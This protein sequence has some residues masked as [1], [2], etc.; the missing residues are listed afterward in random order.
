MNDWLNELG[1]LVKGALEDGDIAEIV[2]SSA[3]AETEQSG[4]YHLQWNDGLS[5][6]PIYNVEL[7]EQKLSDFARWFLDMSREHTALSYKSGHQVQQLISEMFYDDDPV[8]FTLVDEL[9]QIEAVFGKEVMFQGFEKSLSFFMKGKDQLSLSFKTFAKMT[10]PEN[11]EDKELLERNGLAELHK[12]APVNRMLVV[13]EHT[14][15]GYSLY[16]TIT[17]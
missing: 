1:E 14:F 9:E 11:K 16:S 17:A 10:L 4:W 5:H 6:S 13:M 2:V 12:P 15:H 8:G 7:D 3:Y